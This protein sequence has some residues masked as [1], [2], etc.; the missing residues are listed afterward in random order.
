MH[1]H[2][3]G[4]KHF[5]HKTNFGDTLVFSDI[6][7]NKIK[8]TE[9]INEVLF[10]EIEKGYKTLNKWYIHFD[11]ILSSEYGTFYLDQNNQTSGYAKTEEIEY[12]VTEKTFSI[13]EAHKQDFQ[14]GKI[15]YY[16]NFLKMVF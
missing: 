5:E 6:V 13:I 16:P 4:K 7:Q 8:E 14:D 1:S 2:I 9:T 3:Y 12:E 11:R 15:P 10:I